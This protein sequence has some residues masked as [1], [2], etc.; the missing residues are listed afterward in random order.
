[1]KIPPQR[2]EGIAEG[3][4][5]Y[6]AFRTANRI[7]DGQYDNDQ[8]ADQENRRNEFPDIV[9]DAGLT[10]GEQ[11]RDAEEDQQKCPFYGCGLNRREDAAEPDFVSD[12]AASWNR[13]EDHAQD[14]HSHESQVQLCMS[15]TA[16]IFQICPHVADG[17]YRQH[18][19]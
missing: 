10:A 11:E 8:Q 1:M 13:S 16:D 15:V 5:D 18:W 3:I 14:C 7:D 2:M 9:H 4:F 17:G 19:E 6:A 12:A